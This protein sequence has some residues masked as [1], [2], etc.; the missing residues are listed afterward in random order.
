MNIG[1]KATHEMIVKLK[2][3]AYKEFFEEVFLVPKARI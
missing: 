3:G 1:A 2:P